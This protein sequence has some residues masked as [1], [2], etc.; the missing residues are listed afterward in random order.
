MASFNINSKQLSDTC[1]LHLIDPSTGLYMYADEE[2]KEPLTITLF[3]R[4]S[5]EYRAWMAQAVRKSETKEGKK[6][7]SLEE[8]LAENAEFLAKMSKDAQN[9]DMDGVA[10]DSR[11]AFIKLYSNPKLLWIGEQVSEKLSE[12]GNFIQK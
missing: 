7:K 4:A 8:S 5:K 2:E 11:D 9:F 3:G 10:L 12:L 1:V 6:K